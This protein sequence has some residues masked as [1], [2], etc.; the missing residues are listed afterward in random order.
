MKLVLV[1]EL[2]SLPFIVRYCAA[3]DPNPNRL[4]DSETA[5]TS[6]SLPEEEISKGNPI[7]ATTDA[8]N[9]Q[10]GEHSPDHPFDIGESLELH[11]QSKSDPCLSD[12]NQAPSRR[13][14]LRRQSCSSPFIS[15]YRARKTP[16]TLPPTTTW[17]NTDI[18][19]PINQV[20]W[21]GGI[22]EDPK[23]CADDWHNMPVCAP[24]SSAIGD[25]LPSCRPRMSKISFAPPHNDR[26][27]CRIEKN[28]LP[29]LIQQTQ[30][31][32]DIFALLTDLQG[33]ILAETAIFYSAAAL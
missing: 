8:D 27:L 22:R 13:R 11:S 14:R 33:H 19:I 18:N 29:I 9:F 32:P 2:L 10:R 15:P 4:P 30:K 20:P 31:Q 28:L 24:E 6:I 25:Y 23:L 12:K 16:V 3:S 7:S 21:S 1:W 5:S 26:L 17:G